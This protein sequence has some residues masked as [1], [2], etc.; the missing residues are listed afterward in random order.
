MMRSL[1]PTSEPPHLIKLI[2]K[3][4]WEQVVSHVHSNPEDAVPNYSVNR[5]VELS[6]LARAVRGGASVEAIIALTEASIDQLVRTRHYRQGT[7]LH[8]A[9]RSKCSA[10]VILYFVDQIIRNEKEQMWTYRGELKPVELEFTGPDTRLL[11]LISTDAK[12]VTSSNFNRDG[13]LATKTLRH[14]VSN[15]AT[16]LNQTD[17]LGRTPLHYL[18]ERV[19]APSQSRR[20]C[21]EELIHV[22]EALANAFPPAI[23]KED[24]DGL[25]P[26]DLALLSTKDTNDLNQMEV[27]MKLFTVCSILVKEYPMAAFPPLNPLR[28]E[29]SKPIESPVWNSKGRTLNKQTH[30]MRS[31]RRLL[32]DSEDSRI[33]HNTLSRAL[34]HGRHIS[35]IQLLLETSKLSRA[36][37]YTGQMD[38]YDDVRIQ[39]CM[40]I[41]TREFEVPLH[42]AVTMKAPTEVVELLVS[43]APEAA[44][45]PDRCGLTPICWAWIR[46]ISG[47]GQIRVSQ[48][49][50]IPLNYQNANDLHTL[51]L[52][53]F[54]LN[55]RAQLE[56]DDTLKELWT[57]LSHLLPSAAVSISRQALNGSVQYNLEKVIKWS[58][59]HAATFLTCPRVVVLLAAAA[60]PEQ[61]KA[62]DSEGNVPLHY[63]AAR[64]GYCKTLFVG[65]TSTPQRIFE[66]APIHDLAQLDPSCTKVFNNIGRLPLHIAIETEKKLHKTAAHKDGPTSINR[67]VRRIAVIP[68]SKAKMDKNVQESIPLYLSKVDPDT[69]EA[70]DGLSGLYPF[71]QA[72]ADKHSILNTVYN[73]LRESPSIL[74]PL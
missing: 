74:C 24:A 32:S 70:K 53:D 4:E 37:W 7:V 15:G 60:C 10:K 68:Q 14:A 29:I 67:T 54:V 69:L 16:V 31:C 42:I 61:I 57:N 71:M 3:K 44:A 28:A 36:S 72:A 12:K 18:I 33:K 27:E 11:S 56:W 52:V 34:L 51:K 2:N 20:E 50:F 62:P 49:R 41:V 13:S 40:A 30:A 43:S 46:H 17:G 6:A 55:E 1:L 47:P 63:A 35:T 22:V 21:R 64:H 45:V 23:G 19:S 39:Y 8:E 66:A 5:G 73:L 59:L 25:T 26:L 65:P 48:R 58:P 38:S 9:I